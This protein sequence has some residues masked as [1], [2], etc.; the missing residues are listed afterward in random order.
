MTKKMKKLA[1]LVLA[2]VMVFAMT[3]PVMAQDTDN[4]TTIT[5][6]NDAITR[7]YEVYQIFTADVSGTTLSNVKWG[8]NG[9]GTEGT[10]VDEDTLNNIKAVGKP[11]DFG[12]QIT[13]AE[14]ISVYANFNSDPVATVTTGESVEVTFGYYLLKDVTA[15]AVLGNA[16]H[17]LYVVKIAGPT[18]I[19]PKASQTTSEK[20]VKDIDDSTGVETQWQDSADHDINDEIDFQL[21]A[22]IA[23]DYAA[24]DEYYFAFHDKESV[25][26]TFKPDSVK[27]FVDGKQ[28][29]SEYY[30]VKTEGFATGHDCTF[31]VVFDNLKDVESVHA[32]HAGS[33]IT[34][35]YKSTL[36]EDAVIGSLGNP[37][38]MYAEFSNNP[39]DEG[40]GTTQED[41]VIVFTY[42][43]DVNKVTKNPDYNK[44]V[45][46]SEEYMPLAGAGFTLYKW[47]AVE[48]A[49]FDWVQ[50]GEEVYAENLTVFGWKGLDDGKYKLVESHTPAGY[51]TIE[52][53][54]FEISADHEADS[55]DPK[56][57]SL[58]GGDT[59]AG[60]VNLNGEGT[61]DDEYTGVLE[62]KVINNAGIELPETG[63]I[64]TTIFYVAGGILVLAA[65]VLLVTRKRM[66]A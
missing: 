36:N 2:M 39:Y 42:K 48:G 11:E 60:E 15:D 7:T 55:A 40:R 45:E 5:V 58:S 51:N 21:K 28:I 1:A 54:E 47:E 19:A 50:I 61:E 13:A 35:E 37:N 18:T 57:I 53:I 20:K 8:E 65:V 22:T 46:G 9:T 43:L 16:T 25:G 33:V 30:E 32:V 23:E 49:A 27:V 3:I 10:A 31:E 12:E 24:Y 34:V 14:K 26:L 59:F 64:G 6:Q 41:K 63:G 38:V 17:S 52:P 4:T 56:L 44:D 66:N 62:G 29:E